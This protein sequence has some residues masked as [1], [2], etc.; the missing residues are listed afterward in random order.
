MSLFKIKTPFAPAGDQ[1]VA[2]E[3]LVSLR[4]GASTLFGVTGSGKT[5][6]IAHVIQAQEKPVLILAPNKTLAAQLYE[7]FSLFFP[8]NKVCY[9]VSYYDYYQ[10]ESYI[11]SQDVYIAKETKI[12]PELERLRIEA[13]ASLINRSDTI[14]IASVSAIYSLGNPFDYKEL[15]LSLRTSQ[16]M[17]RESLIN[18]LLKIQYKRNDI[19]RSVGTFQ[20]IGNTVEVILPYQK[21]KVRIEIHKGLIEGIFWV[22]RMQNS[23]L[24]DLDNAIIFPAKHFV[25]HD[26]LKEKGLKTIEAELHGWLP[27]LEKDMY[28]ERLYQRVMHDI[29]MIKET[30]FCSGIENYS[31]HFD[32][33]AEDRPPYCLFDFFPKDFLVIVDESHITLPQLRGMYAGDRSRK[34]ALIEYG[35]RLPSAYNNRPLRFEEIEQYF[36][37][38]IFVSATP[39]SYELSHCSTVVEQI[40]RPTGLVDP[41][42][43]IHS[44]ENQ[45]DD[46]CRN[47]QET[48]A[49]GFRTLVMVMT[50]QL[51]EDMADY[52]EDQK[53]AVCYLHSELKTPQRSEL[54]Q[55][56]R[57]GEFDCLVGVNLLREGLDIPE[58][59]FIAIM[60]ADL[61]SFLRDKRSL[62]Q[63]IGRA[64]RN[65]E[66]HVILYADRI[67]DSMKL[68]MEETARRRLLQEQYNKKHKIIAQTVSRSVVKS[69]IDIQKT[70]AKASKRKSMSKK[71]AL[72]QLDT[73]SIVE[74]EKQMETAAERFDFETAIEIRDYLL[75]K[76]Q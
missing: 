25:M 52:L 3:K 75:Q 59:A 20:V 72:N 68:A 12:N 34:S 40:I 8:D 35:F 15:A 16:V 51:A 22:D 54:I 65:N 11:A 46:L 29:E 69:I 43:T 26:E 53:I 39:G 23:V 18:A 21:E 76:K 9:F 63:I 74:L 32:G 19:E 31:S 24:M 55:K 49:K 30:G 57:L 14:V 45:M 10:P 50:K 47:I 60:D 44:R 48:T 1:P 5:C 6:T 58:V 62:I 33:R 4:P 37:D 67:T 61:E 27:K 7:E 2:I 42:V 71:T 70:I 64:A 28:R 56:L 38:V 17:D 73:Y 41:I 66:A 36:N 13:S